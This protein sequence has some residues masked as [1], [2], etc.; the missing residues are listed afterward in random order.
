LRGRSMS[1]RVESSQTNTSW[2]LGDPRLDVRTDGR[3]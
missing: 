2:R 1:I 3:R